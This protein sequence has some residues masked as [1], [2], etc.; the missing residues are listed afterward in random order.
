M[1]TTLTAALVRGDEVA[2]GP[3]RRQPRLRPPRRR[4]EA[5]DQGPLAGRGAPPPG[6]A[7]RRAGRG[8]PAALDHHPRARP[9]PKVNVDTMTFAG[10]DRRR[11]PALQRRPDD[12][13]RRRARSARSSPRPKSLRSAV[14]KLVDAA[15]R[16]G[17]RDNITAVAFRVA[18]RA[19]RPEEDATLISRTAEQAGLTG[20]RMRAAADRLRG[21]GPMPRAARGAAGRSGSP[22]SSPR[23]W[24]LIGGAF[25]LARQVYFLGTDDER[26]GRALPRPPLRAAAGDRPLLGA[27]LD[28]RPGR[29]PLPGAPGGRHRARAA[30]R[31]RRDAT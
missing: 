19:R 23:R 12:D 24:L 21:Q 15:N 6:P 17:G 29:A 25:F 16:G 10:Q 8:A 20:E 27:A 28:R 2:L 7:H 26:P 11:L 30:L 18:R 9:E 1:G 4:A 13:G 31:G 22:R 14:N 5:A 3:R